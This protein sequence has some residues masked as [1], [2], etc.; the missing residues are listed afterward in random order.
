MNNLSMFWILTYSSERCYNS[1]SFWHLIQ[2][3]LENCSLRLFNGHIHIIVCVFVVN[4][5]SHHVLYIQ[6]RRREHSL[7]GATWY[8]TQATGGW[9]SGSIRS[10]RRGQCAYLILFVLCGGHCQTILRPKENWCFF[11]LT[12]DN[13][14]ELIVNKN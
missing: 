7:M 12:L 14:Q 9:P 3:F 5:L 4:M 13:R 2:V 10:Q 1:K 11:T 8:Q 6:P